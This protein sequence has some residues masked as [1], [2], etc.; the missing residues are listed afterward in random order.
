MFKNTLLGVLLLLCSVSL[1][2]D[3]LSEYETQESGYTLGE[4]LQVGEL[5]IY[6]GG[7]FSTDIKATDDYQQYRLDDIALLSYGSYEKLSYM[8]EAEFKEFYTYIKTPDSSFTKK[9]TALHTERLYLEYAFD[10][11]FMGRAGKYNS[12]IGFWNMV[13]VNVLRD[14]S[15]NPKSLDILFPRFTT[16]LLGSYTHYGESSTLQVDAIVQHNDDIDPDY[17]NYKADDHYGLGITY[18]VDDLSLKLNLGTFN[19]LSESYLQ[20]RLS[21]ALVSLLYE[22]DDFKIMS[23]FGSQRAKEGYTTE[24]AGYLQGVYYITSQHAAI[25]RLETYKDKSIAMQDNLSI[26][27]YTYRP[28]YPVAFKFEYQ[29]DSA[30]E[31]EQFVFSFSVL[32]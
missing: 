13:P 25:I 18:S 11:N 15:S 3:E 26:F 14:T 32:F 12:P 24:Y 10:E 22:K 6:I 27:A 7:Y 19:S 16:G 30:Q 8:A 2:A 31:D 4:G 28:L 21:Y 20:K 29:L 5:P 1:T 23:E 17:N 9:D